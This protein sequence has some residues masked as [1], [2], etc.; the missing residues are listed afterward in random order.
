MALRGVP[1]ISLLRNFRGLQRLCV[2]GFADDAP[3]P[4]CSNLGDSLKSCGKTIKNDCGEKTFKK[5]PKKKKG[6]GF[7]FH[8]L[9]SFPDE[10]CEDPCAAMDFPR[11]DECLYEPSDKA[12]RKYQV[13]WVECP[14]IQIKPKKICCY[15]NA[16]HPPIVRR[17]KKEREIVCCDVASECPP[18]DEG[19][20]PRLVLPGCKAARNPSKCTNAKSPSDCR[21]VRAP[22]PS[23]SEC[24]RPKL[25][26]LRRTECHCLESVALCEMF[27]E[28]A[29]RKRG[30][31]GGKGQCPKRK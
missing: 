5:K 23:F 15:Q 30:S 10:C 11:F 12:A 21:K 4:K 2:R 22:Y 1:R 9:I 14:P 3:P 17:K 20:C 16:K 19:P 31:G 29:K 26:K 18:K 8:H 7:Q 28:R 27:A 25:R 24:S 13:T 6:D